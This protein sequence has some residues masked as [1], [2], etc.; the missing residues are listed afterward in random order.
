H[1]GHIP[2]VEANHASNRDLV[3]FIT[4]DVAGE[5]NR[6]GAGPNSPSG[7]PNNPAAGPNNPAGGPETDGPAIADDAN[8]K[9]AGRRGTHSSAPRE[10]IME[11]ALHAPA[12]R[13]ATLPI[14][15]DLAA[16]GAELTPRQYAAPRDKTEVIV[17]GALRT[18]GAYLYNLDLDR[19]LDA[20]GKPL[21]PV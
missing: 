16:L 8:P 10:P 20:Q 21:F 1:C 9:A 6:P 3:E 5:S 12:P 14:G 11:V 2:Q 13:A 15:A 18:R 19:G 7:G 4:K 17:H